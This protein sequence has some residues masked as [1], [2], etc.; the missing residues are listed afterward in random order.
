MRTAMAALWCCSRPQLQPRPNH[1]L[2]RPLIF[3]HT[4]IQDTAERAVFF[5]VVVVPMSVAATVLAA[6]A[7]PVPHQKVE[8]GDFL[9]ECSRAE[10][11]FN[12]GKLHESHV[13]VQAL[14]QSLEAAS[15]AG[16]DVEMATGVL[17]DFGP[18][19]GGVK[20]SFAQLRSLLEYSGMAEDQWTLARSSQ[21]V[22]THY[23]AG[24]EGLATVRLCGRIDA[25]LLHIVA[26]MQES[27]LWASWFTRLSHSD[28]VKEV[29]RFR[30]VVFVRANGIGPV[31]ARFLYLDG[32]GYDLLATAGAVAIVAR[33]AEGIVEKPISSGDVK[34]KLL[35]GG[36]VLVPVAPDVTELV[37]LARADPVL[38]VIPFW[39]LN[40]V[41]K[42]L[43]H[44]FFELMRERA[45]KLLP[46]YKERI[47][48]NPAMYKEVQTRMDAFMWSKKL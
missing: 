38:P 16:E 33:N 43:A 5:A 3:A 23:R 19:F 30:K 22:T 7:A 4:D 18:C 26:V 41:T 2:W 14:E 12:D 9:D 34:M 35:V 42:Q 24:E 44:H 6:V 46:V 10:Q 37:L 15:E 31:G 40:I 32:Q 28:T 13:L 21:G 17:S 36:A 11:L 47:E 48:K 39:L 45:V 8:L 29:S 20:E 1:A 27:D 25:S